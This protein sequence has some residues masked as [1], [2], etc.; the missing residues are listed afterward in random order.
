MM[1]SVLPCD[2]LNGSE[3]MALVNSKWASGL[4]CGMRSMCCSSG[5][6]HSYLLA[7]RFHA[8]KGNCEMN[9]IR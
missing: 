1:Q 4:S 6:G 2:I 8:P 5:P 9:R 7:V 3:V